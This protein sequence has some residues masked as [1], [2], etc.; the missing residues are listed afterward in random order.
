MELTT[1]I[2]H[3]ASSLPSAQHTASPSSAFSNASSRPPSSHTSVHSS[4]KPRRGASS[5]SAAPTSSWFESF[6]SIACRPETCRIQTDF[7]PCSHQG[8]FGAKIKE[9]RQIFSFESLSTLT[10]QTSVA[11][12]A[13]KAGSSLASSF[14]PSATAPSYHSF[15]TSDEKK[16]LQP[17][18][19]PDEHG[20]RV[21]VGPFA[22]GGQG[23]KKPSEKEDHGFE[24][25]W[26]T[27]GKKGER[28]AKLQ[29][30]TISKPSLVADKL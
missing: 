29:G 23:K 11:Y 22:F 17:S 25:A 9:I 8:F 16:D 15:P 24:S 18:S 28:E 21:K 27:Y 1:C 26:G 2:A 13:Y 19:F 4:R 7:S 5:S 6:T 12:G 30:F 10:P 3:S 20:R 14:N